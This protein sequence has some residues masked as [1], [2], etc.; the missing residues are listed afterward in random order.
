VAPTRGP[1]TRTRHHSAAAVG[2]NQP[3]GWLLIATERYQICIL[4]YNAA[5]GEL[6]TVAGGS[7]RRALPPC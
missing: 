6:V 4:S 1:L 5:T 3:V 2:Q 7:V